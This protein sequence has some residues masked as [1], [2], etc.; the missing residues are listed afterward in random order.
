M[1]PMEADDHADPTAVAR[2]ATWSRPEGRRRRVL[3]VTAVLLAAAYGWWAVGL[4]PFS[5]AATVVVVG[6]GAGAV[7]IGVSARRTGRGAGAHA[8]R[9]EQRHDGGDDEGRRVGGSEESPVGAG[10]APTPA[11]GTAGAR[12]WAGWV[13]AVALWQLAAY[14]QHPR[15]DHPTLSSLANSL[16]DSHSARAAAFVLWVLAAVEL[17]RR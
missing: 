5:G 9:F 1:E 12:R 17:A 4:A 11:P 2:Q 7:G 14:L 16:L 8:A 6:A 15:D 3:V 13:A 10:T